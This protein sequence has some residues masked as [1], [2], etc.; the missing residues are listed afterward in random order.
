MIAGQVH[1]KFA[2]FS[3]DMFE[4]AATAAEAFCDGVAAKS[5]AVLYWSGTY[6]ISIGYREDEKPYAVNLSPVRLESP[7]VMSLDAQMEDVSEHVDGEVICHAFFVEN[8]AVIMAAV[9]TRG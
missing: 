4:K 8:A 7:E 9:M 6:H 5:L 3:S 1:E 2:T